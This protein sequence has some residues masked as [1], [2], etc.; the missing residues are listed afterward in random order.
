LE[1]DT[2]SSSE[3]QRRYGNGAVRTERY[4]LAKVDGRLGLG[5]GPIPSWTGVGVHTHSPPAGATGT[6]LVPKRAKVLTINGEDVRTASQEAATNILI[7]AA[8]TVDLVVEV[9]LTN[10]EQKKSKKSKKA[11]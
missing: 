3:W 6:K 9:K 4:I 10:A 1:V 8:V 11:R 7:A 5:I 2:E